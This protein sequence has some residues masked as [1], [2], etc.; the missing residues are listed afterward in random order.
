MAG[1]E[2]L[3]PTKGAS[4]AEKKRLRR[5]KAKEG[6]KQLKESSK[7]LH[8]ALHDA[9]HA[10]AKLRTDTKGK[11]A[12][13]PVHT[14]LQPPKD[15][16]EHRVVYVAEP[17][18]GLEDLSKEVQQAA[19]DENPYDGVTGMEV[20]GAS[21]QASALQELQRI[22]QHFSGAAQD[23]DGEEEPEVKAEVGNA[24]AVGATPAEAD[25]DQDP[26]R[27]LL[28]QRHCFVIVA[29]VHAVCQFAT[30]DC[31]SIIVMMP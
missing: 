13:A 9:Q 24:D 2:E 27:E 16:V 28:L 3:A 5:K 14:L 1:D 26:N 19:I 10:E 7:Q 17:L 6:K 18:T 11:T 25:E 8:D 23:E 12:L 31:L 30:S 21:Q 15:S 22:A 4:A 20:D 29:V